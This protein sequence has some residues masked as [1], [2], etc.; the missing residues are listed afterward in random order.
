VVSG[1]VFP[2][3]ASRLVV[4]RPSET[5]AN[6]GARAVDDLAE[7]LIPG[8]PS[9]KTRSPYFWRELHY[10]ERVLLRR[11]AVMEFVIGLAPRRRRA[12][13]LREVKIFCLALEEPA[14]TARKSSARNM[15]TH[16]YA[17][18]VACLALAVPLANIVLSS[19]LGKVFMTVKMKGLDARAIC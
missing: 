16:G 9:G 8:E 10:V 17:A 6:P 14:L 7:G 18:V 1:R 19:S 4:G 11:V 5:G 2:V 12:P 3:R 15:T 13:A